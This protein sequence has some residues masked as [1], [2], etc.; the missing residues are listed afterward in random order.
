MYDLDWQ[1]AGMYRNLDLY[2]KS[3]YNIIIGI[4]IIR[5]L[6]L[7]KSNIK[8]IYGITEGYIV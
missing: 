8:G 5:A 6:R 4:L 7:D 2:G 3:K 1:P